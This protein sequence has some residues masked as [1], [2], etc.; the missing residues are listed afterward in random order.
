MGRGSPALH[1]FHGHLGGALGRDDEVSGQ[2]RRVPRFGPREGCRRQGQRVDSSRTYFQEGK[3]DSGCQS[4]EA[5]DY[6]SSLAVHHSLSDISKAFAQHAD[7]DCNTLGS[8]IYPASSLKLSKAVLSCLEALPLTSA[9]L[10][11]IPRLL[12]AL[13][14]SARNQRYDVFIQPTSSKTPYQTY[15]NERVRSFLCTAIRE[16]QAHLSSVSPRPAD[17]ALWRCRRDIWRNVTSWG[18]YVESDQSWRDLLVNDVKM[19]KGLLRGHPDAEIVGVLLSLLNIAEGLDH[20]ATNIEVDTMAWCLA[21]RPIYDSYA[22]D[23]QTPL[24]NKAEAEDILSATCRY[25]RLSQSPEIWVALVVTSVEQLLISLGSPEARLSLHQAI[26]EGPLF[27]D[28]IWQQ[29]S[30]I[31]KTDQIVKLLLSRLDTMT[32]LDTST[33][34]VLDIISYLAIALCAEEAI[35]SVIDTIEALLLPIKP[36]R[37]DSAFD[38]SLA[39]LV[40]LGRRSSPEIRAKL[41]SDYDLAG[42]ASAT[43]STELRAEAVSLAS[44]SII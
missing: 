25:H 7:L 3:F 13:E 34:I 22:S 26:V 29:L 30:S 31:R 32:R 5:D 16:T 15:T 18:V 37:R 27:S 11:F 40:R 41:G 21:V 28:A 4:A 10:Q 2:G 14:S 1:S 39:A 44:L 35:T 17:L 24:L 23:M 36:K 38:L 33:A 12:C 43:S 8:I 19:A 9:T 20:T 6:K 42:A